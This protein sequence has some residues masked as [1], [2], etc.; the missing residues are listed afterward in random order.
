MRLK[1]SL[2]RQALFFS[3]RRARSLTF[4][5]KVGMKAPQFEVQVF[6]V[7]DLLDPAGVAAA[8]ERG[9]EPDPDN[10]PGLLG[11]E[12]PAAKGQA[13]RVVVAAAHL[14]RELVPAG[15]RPEALELV[16]HEGYADPGAA[17]EDGPVAGPGDDG[18][19]GQGPVVDIIDRLARPA[20][21]IDE[22]DAG[23]A[24]GGGDVGLE[25][26]AGVVGREGDLHYLS[27]IFAASGM[28]SIALRTTGSFCRE[29][30]I[31]ASTPQIAPAISRS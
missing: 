22:G 15:R 26:V 2:W 21:E 12:R 19:R 17:D 10:G 4:S 5:A 27:I 20:A 23:L 14:G 18:P 29:T 16:G 30:R 31:P 13:V 7:A 11:G 9:L 28:T 8:F 6:E 25:G 24:E 3:V 1:Q